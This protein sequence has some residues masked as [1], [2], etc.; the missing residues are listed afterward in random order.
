MPKPDRFTDFLINF[1][2]GYFPSSPALSPEGLQG[3]IRAG[4]NCWRRPQGKIEVAKGLLQTSSTNVGARLFAADIQR[5]SI[6]GGLVGDILPYAGFLRY[7]NA[8]FL[9]LSENTSAQV[10]LDEVAIT[11]LTTSATPGRLRVAIP[12]GLGGYNVFDAGFDKPILSSSDIS[13]FTAGAGVL[14]Q[15]AMSGAMGV[16]IAPWRTKTNAV[17]PPSEVIYNDIAPSGS[18]MIRIDPPPA[19][20]GQ[21]GWIY[22]ATKWNDRSG[23]LWVF[24]HVYLTPRGTFTAT[25]GSPNLTAGIGTFWNLDLY[26]GDLIDIGGTGYEISN[27]TSDTTATLA[28]NFT[29]ITGSGKT[30]TIGVMAGNWYNSELEIPVSRD[31]VRPPR[32]AGVLQYGKQRV[33]LWGVPDT[34]TASPTAA[35]GNVILA[36]AEGNPEHVLD[37]AVFAIVTQSGS[38]L[39]NVLAG[40]GP[41]YLLTTTSLEIVSFDGG[42]DTPY[43]IRT[44]AEPGFVA[45]TNAALYKDWL[46]FF[47]GRPG[48]TRARENIDVVFAQPVWEDMRDWDPARVIVAVD[49]LND[50]ILYMYDDG[51]T[52]VV[53]PFM[54]QL[55]VWGP[56]LNFPARIIDTA[57]VNGKLYVTY[58]SGGDYRVNEW[59]GGTGIGGVRYVASQYYD[60]DMLKTSRLKKV[61]VVGKVGT[62]YIYAVTPDA[63]VPDVSDTGAAVASFALS[64]AAN[65]RE[66]AVRTNIRG[67]AFA[68]RLEFS[69]NDGTFDKMVV[70]GLP[71]GED[72]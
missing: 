7:Q 71:H 4:S 72:H 15:K 65:K 59:E 36:C 42:P 67:D 13:V 51:S 11:G 6:A 55:N 48:R 50:A 58:L 46:Y 14:G 62:L 68:F 54:A 19:V 25:N 23:A 31:I 32:A 64:N 60:P 52:T 40:D 38:D 43:T 9:Y 37:P 27:I 33:F 63:E 2:A 45:G 30:M 16:A 20:S 26:R 5:A 21:D 66:L 41:L 44:V 18:V 56:P 61:T 28:A 70:G 12:D 24:R 47:N 10:Y 29:G 53:L 34:T 69:S 49:P 8:A 22:C 17:G 35:T 3:T 57:V 39:V 1:E